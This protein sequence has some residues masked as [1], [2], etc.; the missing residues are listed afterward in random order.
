MTVAPFLPGHLY[1]KQNCIRG[2][3]PGYSAT[4]APPLHMGCWGRN[5]PEPGADRPSTW[6][7]TTAF[8]ADVGR[9]GPGRIDRKPL[10]LFSEE[11]QT[12]SLSS[13][14][15]TLTTLSLK[16][17]CLS[18]V[19]NLFNEEGFYAPPS[20]HMEDGTI[21]LTPVGRYRRWIY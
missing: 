12:V 20:L 13:L 19:R 3:C 21:L 10:K 7:G 14:F 16:K 17:C 8:G 15:H 4:L 2:T 9:I 11:A 5:D 6:G 1:A 18:S